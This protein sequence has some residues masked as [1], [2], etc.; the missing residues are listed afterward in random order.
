MPPYTILMFVFSIALLLYAGLLALTKN[1]DLL[2]VRARISVNPKN[3]KAYTF[4]SCVADFYRN[5]AVYAAW[6]SRR[7]R[8]E[9]IQRPCRKLGKRGESGNL[10]N[11]HSVFGGINRERRTDFAIPGR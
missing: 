2:P 8:A 4:Q 5:G 1:Y 7:V 10:D 3:K 9:P 11:H 6:N